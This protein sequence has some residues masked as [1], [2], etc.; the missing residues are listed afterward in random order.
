MRYLALF[1]LFLLVEVT[2][3]AQSVQPYPSVPEIPSAYQVDFNTNAIPYKWGLGFISGAARG[4]NQVLAFHP[5]NFFARYP[6]A[7]RQ[8][9]DNSVSWRNK[10]KNGDP[11]QGPAFPFSRNALVF[12]TDGFHA[13]GTISNFTGVVSLSIP[14]YSGSGKKVKDYAAEAGISAIGYWMGF[15]GAYSLWFSQDE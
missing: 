1:C 2:I 6:D 3:F 5:N 10:H 15:H 9:W 12:L 14:L 13:T 7:N 4:L 8:Y 11:A